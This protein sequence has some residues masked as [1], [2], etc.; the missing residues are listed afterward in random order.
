MK[1]ILQ[2]TIEVNRNSVGKIAEQIGE[3]VIK[4]NWESYI[5]Y[6]RSSG[7]SKSKLIKIGTFLDTIWHVAETRLFANHASSSRIA[8]YFLIRKIKKIIN[9]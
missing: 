8:T 2:I 5:T 6:S 4:N 9:P 7:Q 1:K 3:V